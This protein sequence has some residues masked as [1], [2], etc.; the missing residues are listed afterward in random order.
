MFLNLIHLNLNFLCATV[1]VSRYETELANVRLFVS[2]F[3]IFYSYA[4]VY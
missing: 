2:L 1:D 4:M 3:K